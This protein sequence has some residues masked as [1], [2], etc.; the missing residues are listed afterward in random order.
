MRVKRC[1]WHLGCMFAN[2]VSHIAVGNAVPGI[3]RIATIGFAE[4]HGGTFPTRIC[5]I[6]MNPITGRYVG[7][8][9]LISI[10]SPLGEEVDFLLFTQRGR[11]YS[12]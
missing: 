1:N 7:G 12:G 8:S 6:V 2:H 11:I 9:P 10:F 5:R 3:P 4:R